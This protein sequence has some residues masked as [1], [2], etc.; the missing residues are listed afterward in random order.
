MPNHTSSSRGTKKN[1]SIRK[2]FLPIFNTCSIARPVSYSI[3]FY[4]FSGVDTLPSP[5]CPA[6]RC[7]LEIPLELQGHLH[8][9]VYI[10][11]QHLSAVPVG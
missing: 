5:L 6:A 11:Q 1:R 10:N 7:Y 9:S 3:E 4:T 2:I 8:S